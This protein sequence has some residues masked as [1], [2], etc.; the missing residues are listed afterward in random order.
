M[1][2]RDETNDPFPGGRGQDEMLLKKYNS[3]T[4]ST[5]HILR[6]I[7]IMVNSIELM[8]DGMLNYMT[9]LVIKGGLHAKGSCSTRGCFKISF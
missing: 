7:F 8:V 5:Y 9:S 6:K 1:L 4:C 2:G 3:L